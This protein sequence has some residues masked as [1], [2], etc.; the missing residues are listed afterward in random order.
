TYE[1]VKT[2]SAPSFADTED[3]PNS[4]APYVS[5][6]VQRGYVTGRDIDGKLCFAPHESISRAEAAVI[7]SNI[8]GYAKQ[9]TVTAFA[10]ADEMPAW[11]V[12]ALT[13]LKSFGILL[14]EDGNADARATMTRGDTAIWLNRTLRVISGT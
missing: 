13:S 6:A 11:S 7:L 3:I 1:N 5:L 8:I 9:T 2:L 4:M 14:P 10:D 12:K